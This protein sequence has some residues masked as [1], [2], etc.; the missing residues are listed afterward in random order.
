M[1]TMIK[2]LI[3]LVAM[4][5]TLFVVDVATVATESVSDKAVA[6][7]AVQVMDDT[8]E[9][10]V[11]SDVAIQAR[12]DT[13]GVGL[14]VMLVKLLIFAGFIGAIFKTLIKGVNNTPTI[15]TNDTPTQHKKET[16]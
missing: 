2:M 4:F 11:A 16:P 12:Q 1:K 10:H 6:I 15:F 13:A 14:I 3:L 5:A 7:T 8:T 9:S